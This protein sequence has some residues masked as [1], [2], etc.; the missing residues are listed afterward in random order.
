[1]SQ[2]KYL[3]IYD[4]IV[5]NILTDIWSVGS[6]M[7][8]EN[9][10]IK[11]FNV[12][13][14]TI[15]NVLSI[16]ENEGRIKRSRGKKTLILDR[17]LKNPIK[18]EIK[19]FSVTINADY[20]LIDVEIVKNTL[21]KKFTNSSSLYFIERLRKLKNNENYLISRAYIPTE[22]I[23]EIKSKNIFEDKNLLNV[24]IN[25]FKIKFSRSSQEISPILL[26]QNDAKI[27]K[28]TKDMPAISNI[29][30][31]YDERDNLALIDQEI[32]V[33]TLKVNNSYT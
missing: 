15:R 7:K 23:G 18:S 6:E 32:T 27:F 2:P 13:R 20:K 19:D 8:S 30:Y 22:L 3:K 10:L 31:F 1:M 33:R 24:L 5:K 9:E 17:L 16:L 4:Q 25:K 26:N 29:W 11:H 12:S 28:T 14:L 21:K